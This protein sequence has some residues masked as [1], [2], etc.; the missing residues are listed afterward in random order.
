MGDVPLALRRAACGACCGILR[1]VV[2]MRA[3]TASDVNAA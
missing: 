1:Y 2:A 3:I